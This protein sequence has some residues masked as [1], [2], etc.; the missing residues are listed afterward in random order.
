MEP[1]LSET[2]AFEAMRLFLA[3]FNER[4]PEN[5][6]DTIDMLL[7]WTEIQSDGGTSDPAQWNDWQR[8]V[9]DALAGKRFTF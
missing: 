8:A 4:E 3:Q 7:A 2:Q 9:A 1:T 5:R 6:R